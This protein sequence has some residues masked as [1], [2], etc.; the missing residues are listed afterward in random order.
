GLACLDATSEGTDALS[1]RAARS[2]GSGVARAGSGERRGLQRQQ[3][4]RRGSCQPGQRKLR[5]ATALSRRWRVHAAL[6][7]TGREQGLRPGSLGKVT[8]CPSPGPAEAD[9]GAIQTIGSLTLTHDVL[10]GNMASGHGGG[11][12]GQGPAS[13]SVSAT[14]LTG[15]IAC[16]PGQFGFNSGGG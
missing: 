14:T 9:G 2:R 15:N 4:E 11:V 16:P 1:G 3:H 7:G 8:S 13:I 5:D 12:V 6:V 10:T